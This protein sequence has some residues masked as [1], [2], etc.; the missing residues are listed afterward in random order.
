MHL[1]KVTIRTG[2]EPATFTWIMKPESDEPPLLHPTIF[3]LAFSITFQSNE[4]S[5]TRDLPA[6]H[7][8]PAVM[9]GPRHSEDADSSRV[10]EQPALAAA[11][12]TL[13]QL[14]LSFDSSP[15]ASSVSPRHV[16]GFADVGDDG[17]TTGGLVQML[18]QELGKA[19]MENEVLTSKY[20]TLVTKLTAMR[21]SVESKLKR[22]AVRH[23]LIFVNFVKLTAR[24]RRSLIEESKK[25]SSLLRR[26]MTMYPPSRH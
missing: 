1:Q 24:R 3:S 20:N 4:P 25:F 5:T 23:L 11:N 19:K 8:R 13:A 21:T 7:G 14:R 17:E 18:K 6:V 10:N 16:N 22:D 9:N 26:T 15:G 12:E 2:L